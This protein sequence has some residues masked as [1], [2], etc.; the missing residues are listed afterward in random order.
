MFPGV[1]HSTLNKQLF[2]GRADKAGSC[3]PNQQLE[4]KKVRSLGLHRGRTSKRFLNV[5][6][7]FKSVCDCPNSLYHKA[8]KKLYVRNERVQKEFRNIS[9]IERVKRLQT[10]SYSDFKRGCLNRR[11]TAFN[12][13]GQPGS[14]T[15][16]SSGSLL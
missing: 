16:G 3:Q 13:R 5:I 2:S 7:F 15:Q 10:R 12:R 4:M 1:F 9:W 8:E 6:A 11:L 14:S